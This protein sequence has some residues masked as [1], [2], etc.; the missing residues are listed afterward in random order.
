M[1]EAARERMATRREPITV[2]VDIGAS[3]PVEFVAKPLPWTKRNDVG[4][5]VNLMYGAALTHELQATRD[6]E[7]N[8]TAL[9]GGLFEKGMDYRGL[10]VLGYSEYDV[11]D[12]GEVSVKAE[13]PKSLMGAFNRLE[14]DQ[15]IEV[16][17]AVLDVNGLDRI[18]HLLDPERKKA[19]LIG[20][21]G[22]PIS[23]T[24]DA[25]EKQ[26]SVTASG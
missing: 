22:P 21:S 8:L 6:E 18:K 7:G 16:L 4:D 2:T 19:L 24:T 26:E 13:P 20:E 9:Q 3:K 25:G 17:T 12:D 14:F 11:D 1:A 5:A 23:E 15:M 10:F